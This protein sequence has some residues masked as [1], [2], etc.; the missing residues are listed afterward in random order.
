MGLNRL[1]LRIYLA[2]LASLLVFALLV[3]LSWKLFVPHGADDGR[4]D[5]DQILIGGL[6]ADL[7]PADGRP[8]DWLPTMRRWSERLGIG[9]SIHDAQGRTL[10]ATGEGVPLLIARERAAADTGE[11]WHGF[12]REQRR[13][14]MRLPGNRYLAVTDPDRRWVGRWRGGGVVPVLGALVLIGI[15][16]A[17]AAWPLAR[18]LTRRVERLERSMRAFGAGDLSTR[19]DVRGR[20][21][22][23]MLAASFNRSADQIERLVQAQKSLLANASHEL[24]SPLAR[25]RMAG[26]LLRERGDAADPLHEELTRSVAELDAL[27]DEI[28]LASRLDAE[29][30]GFAPSSQFESFDLGGLVAEEAARAG[31]VA[32][33]GALELHGDARLLRRLVRNLIENGLR[34]G[35]SDGDEPD[36]TITLSRVADDLAL[37]RVCDRGPGVP[38]AERDRI[39]EPFYR[40]RGRSEREGGVGLGLALVRRIAQRH[41]G[42]ARCL[43]RD[44]GGSCFEVRLGVASRPPR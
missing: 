39:F 41:G 1:V 8:Q 9:L 22:I 7:F 12:D 37:L 28:L 36:L 40:A 11:F 19:T 10:V 4:A 13:L 15:A 17:I 29:Q 16:V 24:R 21:E 42:D 31:L 5:I 18:W 38:E 6:V 35:R 23:G 30:G 33:T 3:G 14:A 32:D 20:D 44:G 27:V 2:V 34:Y 25:I 26:A 43:G